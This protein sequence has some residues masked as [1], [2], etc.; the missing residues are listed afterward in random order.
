MVHVYLGTV[1]VYEYYNI[2]THEHSKPEYRYSSAR[3]P[4]HDV[5]RARYTVYA[6][7]RGTPCTPRTCTLYT[8]G[9]YRYLL[10]VYNAHVRALSTL[11]QPC[12]KVSWGRQVARGF[13]V[14]QSAIV[15][16]FGVFFLGH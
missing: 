11:A 8:S 15:L 9:R 16:L 14:D 7:H 12:H 10:Y 6:V 13:R 1:S 4:W 2:H 3:V 5:R